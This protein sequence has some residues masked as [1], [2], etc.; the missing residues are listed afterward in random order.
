M[1][2]QAPFLDPAEPILRSDPSIDD[3][4]RAALWNIFHAS[5]DHN[6]LAQKLQPLAIPNDTKHRLFVAKQATAPVVEPVEKVKAAIRQ[7][8][9][10]SPDTLEAAEKYPNVTKL[11]ATAAQISTEKPSG[12]G[13]AAGKGKQAKKPSV[14]PDVNPVPPGHALVQTSDRQLHHIPVENIDKAKMIDPDLKVLH[15]EGE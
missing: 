14:E 13:A 10:M 12:E 9:Q 7:V 3:E 11:L 4:G 5:K 6:E 15:V 1:D 2:A 8:A